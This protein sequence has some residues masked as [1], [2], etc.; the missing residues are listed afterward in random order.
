M[1]VVA[2]LLCPRIH[3]FAFRNSSPKLMP[4]HEDSKEL[5]EVKSS[6]CRLAC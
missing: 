6:L 3:E 4:S 5:E 2:A 1:V